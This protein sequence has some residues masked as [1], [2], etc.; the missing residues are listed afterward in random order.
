V[1]GSIK[2]FSMKKEEDT[3]GSKSNLDHDNEEEGVI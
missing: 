1:T 2:L 3:F